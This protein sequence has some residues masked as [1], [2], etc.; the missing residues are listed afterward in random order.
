MHE[1]TDSP[2]I[3]GRDL[4][5]V[6]PTARYEAGFREMLSAYRA[7]GG[8][9]FRDEYGDPDF[10]IDAYVARLHMYS[11]GEFLPEHWVRTSTFWLVDGSKVLGTGRLRHSLNLR[12]MQDGGNIGYDIHPLHRGKGYGNEILRLM[13]LEAGKIGMARVL[14]TCDRDNTAS[15]KIIGRHGGVFSGESLIKETGE[16]MQK[17]WITL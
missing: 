13:L 10:D 14:L 15:R 11:R 4:R 1:K 3:D 5:L 6:R 2:R 17:F 9:K 16:R 12:L 7:L 8:E